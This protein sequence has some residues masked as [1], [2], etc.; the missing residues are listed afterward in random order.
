M[1]FEREVARIHKMYLHFRQV[2]SESYCK[3]N[4]SVYRRRLIIICMEQI[5]RITKMEQC[6]DQLSEAVQ[7]LSVA[8][9]KYAEAQNAARTL[10]DY[11][12]SGEWR[13]DYEADE[14]G[15][16]PKDLKRGVLSEDGLWNVLG[17]CHELDIRMLETVSNHLK[18]H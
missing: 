1:A 16:L 9:D 13:E 17:D 4:L 18:Q 11:L 5:A 12:G 8:L 6:L 14:A 15:L 7:E 3:R 2:P 10:S